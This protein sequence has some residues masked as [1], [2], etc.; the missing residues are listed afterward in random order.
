[1]KH[2]T[3]RGPGWHRAAAGLVGCALAAHAIAG[4]IPADSATDPPLPEAESPCFVIEHIEVQGDEV[5]RFG[6]LLDALTL[7]DG[8]NGPLRRCLGAEGIR[9]VVQRAQRAL[10]ARG[11]VTSRVLVEPQQLADGRLRL[12]VIPGRIRQVRFAGPAARHPSV[13]TALPARPGDVLDLRD[14][15]Q[16]L[17]NL[18]RVP[19]VEADIEIVPGDDPGLSDLLVH[20]TQQRPLRLELSVDNSGSRDTGRYRGNATLGLHNPLALNDSFQIGLQRGPGGDTPGRRHTRGQGAQG[21][22]LNRALPICLLS[23]P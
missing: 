22:P 20:W 1:M 7:R 9:I 10:V 15:E 17:E 18:R 23:F 14:V 6:W 2:P 21:R 3:A 16:A 13:L 11:F 19:T 4:Q 5:P 8:R 12:S